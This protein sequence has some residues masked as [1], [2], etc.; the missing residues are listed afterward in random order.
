MGIAAYFVSTADEGMTMMLA[1]DKG[2]VS[3]GGS[4]LVEGESVHSLH[5]RG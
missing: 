1:V 5:E 3:S 2:A 4:G